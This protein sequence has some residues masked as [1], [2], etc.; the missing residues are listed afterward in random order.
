MKKRNYIFLSI[1][2]LL[3]A[4][5]AFRFYIGQSIE[6]VLEKEFGQEFGTQI[7]TGPTVDLIVAVGDIEAGHT[8]KL[9]DLAKRRF[10]VKELEKNKAEYIPSTANISN[11]LGKVVQ[12]NFNKGDPLALEDLE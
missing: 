11:I 12:K 9:H 10:Y 2:V 7:E 4:F 1:L 3:I 5:L 8:L 6:N